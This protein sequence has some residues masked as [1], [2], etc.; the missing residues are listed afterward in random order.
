ME[1]TAEILQENASHYTV[2]KYRLDCTREL[3]N[4]VDFSIAKEWEFLDQMTVDNPKSYQVWH[5]RQ[6]L[7]DLSPFTSEEELD[8]INCNEAS[9]IIF[10]VS[11][12]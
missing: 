9:N 7:N 5:A 11:G 3:L 10:S 8:F 2:W 12:R 4:Q 1:L 6:A